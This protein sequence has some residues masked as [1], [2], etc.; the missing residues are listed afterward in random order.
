VIVIPA[1]DIRG[2]ACVRLLRGDPHAETIYDDDPVAVARRWES[3]GARRLH[4][5][6]LDRAFGTGSNHEAV[7]TICRSVAIPVQVGGGL[8]SEEAIERALHDGA[9]RALL[10]TVA[11]MDPGFVTRA[12]A[13][14]HDRVVVA[15]DVSGGRAMVRGWQEEGP[16]IEELFEALEAAG[17]PRYLVTAIARDGTLEGPDFELY[18]RVLRLTLRPVIASGGVSTAED[19]HAL[20]ELGMEAAVVGKAL[21]EGTVRIPEVVR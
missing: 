8:R 21:Y 18:A 13:R 5:V 10:G 20:R 6:D 4:V 12:V 9:A 19:V 16:T 2:G 17:T 11:A 3:E 15:V 1:I 14:F 7:E